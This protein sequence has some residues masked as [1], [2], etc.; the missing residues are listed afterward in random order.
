MSAV[1]AAVVASRNAITPRT[2]T[3]M[4]RVVEDKTVRADASCTRVTTAYLQWRLIYREAKA[5]WVIMLRGIGRLRR[6]S[7][8]TRVNGAAFLEALHSAYEGPAQ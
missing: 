8:H 1:T 2:F 5:H 3:Q 4:S 7:R 6:I